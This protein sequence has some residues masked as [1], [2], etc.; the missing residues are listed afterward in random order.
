VPPDTLKP[1]VKMRLAPTLLRNQGWPKSKFVARIYS[2]RPAFCYFISAHRVDL[3]S[4][5]QLYT[6][7]IR[8]RDF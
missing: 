7:L 5:L 3:V 8:S 1:G 6:Q 4:D 2:R